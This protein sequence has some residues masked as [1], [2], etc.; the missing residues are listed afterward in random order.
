[1]KLVEQARAVVTFAYVKA[2][3]GPFKVI[4]VFSHQ[5]VKVCFHSFLQY[6]SNFKNKTSMEDQS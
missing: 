5:I 2:D 4:C 6:L 3:S 1:M